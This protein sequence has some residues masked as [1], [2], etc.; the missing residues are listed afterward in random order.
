MKSATRRPLT[1]WIVAFGVV[2]V[3]VIAGSVGL[4]ASGALVSGGASTV[5]AG[6]FAT[7]AT[8][9]NGNGVIG[10]APVPASYAALSADKVAAALNRVGVRNGYSVVARDLSNGQV[11]DATRGDDAVIP[12][13]SMKLMTTSSVIDKLGPTHTFST[14]VMRQPDGSIT[15]VGGGDVLLASTPTSYA[16]GSPQPATT[17]DLAQRT[18]DALKAAGT[19]SVTLGYDDSL[20]SGATRH[21]DWEPGDMAYV[22][23]ISALMVDEGGGS[24]TP[25]ATAAT[26]FA[27]QLGANGISVTGTPTAH[28]SQSGA[29]QLA[30][31]DSLPLSQIVQECLRHSD[32]TIAE[33]LFRHLA[34]AY[35]QPGSF[36]GGVQALQQEMTHLGLWSGVDSLHDG[37]GLS[38]HDRLTASALTQVITL[39]AGRDD[40][41]NLLAGLPVAAATGSLE[42]RFIDSASSAGGGRV[43]AKTGTLDTASALVGY[44][45]TADGGMVAFAL[46]GNGV[47]AEV[48]PYLDQMAGALSGCACAA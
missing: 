34:I 36:D 13:S 14:R 45:P 28:V 48:R 33:V 21:P 8:N 20:F 27:R 6:V 29:T 11:L 26:T 10:D 17:Q 9:L 1:R 39:A 18:A 2:L 25:A 16:Y 22:N 38:V 43:R 42:T 4:H 12:A 46:V 41:R 35:G 44:T 31:V 7:P 47:G 5:P 30:A 23:D 24:T 32:N 40:L 15:L 37:S 3:L 19:T